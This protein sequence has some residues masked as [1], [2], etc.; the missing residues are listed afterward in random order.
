MSNEELYAA[1][2]EAI[3]KL[4]SDMSVTPEQAKEN[5]ENLIEEIEILIETL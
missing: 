4:Y 1:A 2:L 3:K 5:L